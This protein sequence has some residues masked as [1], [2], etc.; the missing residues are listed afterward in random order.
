MIVFN[1][2]CKDR[3][4]NFT[5]YIKAGELVCINEEDKEILKTLF[6]LL[7]GQAE[8]DKGVIRYLD[9]GVY[10]RRPPRNFIGFV[11]KENLLLPERTLEENL[12]YIMQVR[13]L[14]MRN[15][16][17]MIRR[18]LEIVDLQHCSHKKAGELLKHQLV[19][20]NIAQG[21]LNYPPVLVLEDP[22]SELDELNAQG[23]IRLI[24][25]LNQFSM[26]IILLNSSRKILLGKDARQIRMKEIYPERKDYYG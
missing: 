26:T 21:I 8:P 6:K 17:V 1:K 2:V 9:K 19:R 25:R 10:S 24:K 4:K 5:L 13:D 12:A 7:N 16:Q 18:I 14:E 20:A 3:I 22:C 15:H 23:I 11:H